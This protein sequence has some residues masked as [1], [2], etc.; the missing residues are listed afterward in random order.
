MEKKFICLANSR[1]ASGR[2]IAGK[3]LINGVPS[4]WVR[5]IS[6][7]DGHEIS[8]Y[9]RSY[10]DGN[11]AQVFDIIKLILKGKADHPLQIEN[12]IIDDQYYWSKKGRYTDSLD[13]L[14]DT[15][16]SLWQI[17]YSSY[18]GVNDR[19]PVGAIH[20]AGQSLYFIRP[21]NLEIVVRIEGAAFGNGKKKVRAAFSYRDVDYLITVTDP[22]VER[23]YLSLGEGRHRPTRQCYMTVSLGEA[24]EGYYYKLAAGI[25]EVDQ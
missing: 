18:N 9:D 23:T 11:T 8:E 24:F 7:R 3:E 13:L 12:Y 14:L 2:C 15:P 6:E 19:V 25:F 1:K 17:G 22:E 20:A 10:E 16:D 5:P 21:E 4:S